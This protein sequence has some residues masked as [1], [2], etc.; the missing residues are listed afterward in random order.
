VNFLRGL[1]PAVLTLLTLPLSQIACRAAEDPEAEMLDYERAAKARG[2]RW[3]LLEY[4][5]A[6]VP[7]EEDAA[8]L[9]VF[10][11]PKKYERLLDPLPALSKGT[12]SKHGGLPAINWKVIRQ[13]VDRAG[14]TVD[15]SE[16]DHVRALDAALR[17][18]QPIVDQLCQSK[19]TAANWGDETW[20]GNHEASFPQA[21]IL[22]RC[23]RLL[24]LRANL[25]LALGRSEDARQAV[26]A[27]FRLARVSSR[28]PTIILHLVTLVGVSLPR[29]TIWRGIETGAWNDETLRSFAAELLGWNTIAD[30]RWSLDSERAWSRDAGKQTAH[31]ADKI[32]EALTYNNPETFDIPELRKLVLDPAYKAKNQL[33]WEHS[34]DEQASML[35][36]TTGTWRP[37]ERKFDTAKL[38]KAQRQR[39]LALC[40]RSSMEPYLRKAV[41]V[42]AYNHMAAIG[43]GL[44]LARRANGKYPHT[45]DALVPAYLPRIP[46]DPTSGKGFRY[47]VEPNGSYVLYSVGFDRK[48]DGGKIGS[49]DRDP[50][51]L[52]WLWF[53]PI[54]P[55]AKS[56]R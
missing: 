35:D 3:T 13:N 49:E 11:T 53:A 30:F 44:E 48:D 45:L 25:D 21:T 34:M 23:F 50:S 14:F 52:D 29:E 22:M 32:I 43:C 31:D 19:A 55:S 54:E 1:L 10:A 15:A 7:P 36:P 20:N 17:S 26:E 27:Q 38:T 6:R 42:H 51:D 28:I 40:S 39:D 41:W 37:V 4:R 47:R 24:P 33:W 46:I 2:G 8:L 18:L 5:P 56:S 9:P 12:A 16:P